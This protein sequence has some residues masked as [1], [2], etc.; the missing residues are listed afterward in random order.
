MKELISII[1][2][3]YNVEQYLDDCLISIINQ[4]QK[5]LEIILI[6]DGSTD[7]SGKICDEYAKKDSRIIVIHK[8]NG[9]V[10]SARNAG[11]RIAKGAY[12]GFVDPDDWIAEDMYEVLYSNAKKYDADVSV[13]KYK[14][15]KNRRKDN[16]N[17]IN[18]IKH[19]KTIGLDAIKSMCYML[20]SN[21]FYDCGPCNKL[22]K[23]EVVPY[24]N[25]NISVAEDLL[26]NFEIYFRK[27]NVSC[28]DDSEKYFY[29]Y[30]S[31]SACHSLNFTKAQLLEIDIWENMLFKISN[32]NNF[33]QIKPF[34]IYSMSKVI[35]ASLFK[36]A[37]NFNAD[38]KK[39][40]A[41]LKQKY[42]KNLLSFKNKSLKDY[43]LKIF[44]YLP[45][46][47]VGYIY[48]IWRYIKFNNYAK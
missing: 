18:L 4:T 30:R 25:Q 38:N 21:K 16:L 6:D 7:K 36:L 44:Y 34:V 9:G 22:Y 11:L 3:V 43:I 5:N 40:Y 37:Y 2:P 33:K 35:W 17:A 14:I 28:W 41:L 15:V 29:Y 19:N 42:K 20:S 47:L 46:E 1:V 39:T 24:F 26:F 48:K 23:K 12:I 32:S 8:E 10:S 31:D 45:Y 27:E 13:C